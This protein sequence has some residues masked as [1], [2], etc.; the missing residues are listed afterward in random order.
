MQVQ[1]ADLLRLHQDQEQDR[2]EIGWVLIE[3]R[4]DE[5]PRQQEGPSRGRVGHME[6]PCL[7]T[8]FPEEP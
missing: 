8:K 2:E 5:A 4:Q 6:I 7:P 1:T 3:D